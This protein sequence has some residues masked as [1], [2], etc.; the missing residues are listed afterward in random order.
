[1]KKNGYAETD[2]DGTGMLEIQKI[3]ELSMFESD[4]DAIEQAIKDGVK[5]IPVNELPKNFDRRYLGW[6]DTPQNRKAIFDY[7]YNR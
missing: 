5:V 6:I 2:F 1:M 4:D 7:C 3:D